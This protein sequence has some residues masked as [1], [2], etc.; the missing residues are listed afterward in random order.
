MVLFF[1][2]ECQKADYLG[3]MKEKKK[4]LDKILSLFLWMDPDSL[5]S[6]MPK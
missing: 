3:E 5:H 6:E 4:F 1:G 2:L